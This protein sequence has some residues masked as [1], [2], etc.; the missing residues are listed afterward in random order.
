[1]IC[2]PA[3]S[4]RKLMLLSTAMPLVTS[5]PFQTCWRCM[6]SVLNGN[7]LE[8]PPSTLVAEV[9][10]TLVLWARAEA[11][12]KATAAARAATERACGVKRNILIS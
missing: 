2:L 3:L 7:A 8:A 12:G 4:R 5:G 9:G 11:Q 1:M 6:T 10:M